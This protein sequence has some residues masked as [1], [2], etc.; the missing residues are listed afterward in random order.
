M[1]ELSSAA[2]GSATLP[3]LQ[4]SVCAQRGH[5]CHFGVVACRPCAAF[6]R[7][8]FVD[9]EYLILILFILVDALQKIAIINAFVGRTNVIFGKVKNLHPYHIIEI[10]KN[11]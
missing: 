7:Q 5:G 2:A 11:K 9:R 4:C 6:F 8:E 3:D 1:S 10:N